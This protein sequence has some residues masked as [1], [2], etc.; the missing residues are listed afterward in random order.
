MSGFPVAQRDCFL[1]PSGPNELRHLFVVL[2]DP[3]KHDGILLVNVTSCHPGVP[4]DPACYLHAG[5]HRF[6]TH[7]SYI[8]YS[9]ARFIMKDKLSREV[10]SQSFIPYPPKMDV[11]VF[12]RV[13]AGVDSS[14]DI[15]PR[16][17]TF[18][19]KCK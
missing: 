2:T 8:L 14:A 16:V 17:K 11:A 19:V 3:A 1:V 6:I 10:A 18:A 15:D 9:K 7:Q 5:D 4:D 13:L 12:A